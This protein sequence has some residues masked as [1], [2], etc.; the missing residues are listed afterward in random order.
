MKRQTTTTT[1]KT[2]QEKRVRYVWAKCDQQHLSGLAEEPKTQTSK[3]CLIVKQKTKVEMARVE[4]VRGRVFRWSELL[5]GSRVWQN[6][7]AGRLVETGT[8]QT[9]YISF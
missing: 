7:L 9:G 4:L 3:H 2:L 8:S 5:A 6:R 1:K